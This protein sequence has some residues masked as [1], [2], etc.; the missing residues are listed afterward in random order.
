MAMAEH[1]DRDYSAGRLVFVERRNSFAVQ[2]VTSPA[3]ST[4]SSKCFRGMVWT[5]INIDRTVLI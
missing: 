3:T 5:R 2:E 4:V 1:G